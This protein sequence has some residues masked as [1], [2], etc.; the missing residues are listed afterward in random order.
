MDELREKLFKVV[1]EALQGECVGHCNHPPCMK[2]E[3]IADSLIANGVTMQEWIPASEPPKKNG[4][5][6]CVILASAVGNE[7]KYTRKILYWEDNVW[8][9]TVKSYRIENPLY[10]MPMEE[11]PEPPKGE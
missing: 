1:C 7:R 11:M 10:W 9:S 5:Y 4:D 3:S 2:V 8:I 6:L